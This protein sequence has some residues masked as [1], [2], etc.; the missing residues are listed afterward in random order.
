VPVLIE[1]K[2]VY[3]EAEIELLDKASSNQ[4]LE[5]DGSVIDLLQ[6]C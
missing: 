4:R 2:V 5:S 3:I 6:S 1:N